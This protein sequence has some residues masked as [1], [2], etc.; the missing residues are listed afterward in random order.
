MRGYIVTTSQQNPPKTRQF[1]Y[2]N[3]TD[4]G[5]NRTRLTLIWWADNDARPIRLI[6][7]AATVVVM[8]T[9]TTDNGMNSKC[10]REFIL[11]P[12]LASF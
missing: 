10:Y 7:T 8:R 11:L 2:R 3:N 9:Y 1:L 5:A 6:R 4:N 12:N